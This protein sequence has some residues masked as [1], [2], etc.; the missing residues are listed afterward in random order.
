[1]MLERRCEGRQLPLPCAKWFVTG[2]EGCVSSS[3]PHANALCVRRLLYITEASLCTR[4]TSLDS[5][6]EVLE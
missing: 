2:I 1:M 4:Q 3:L 5:E 6:K